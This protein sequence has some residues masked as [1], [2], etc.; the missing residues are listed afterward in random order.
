MRSLIIAG[1]A[2]LTLAACEQ[3]SCIPEYTGA[4]GYSC[5]KFGDR[6]SAKDREQ[7]AMK[8]SCNHTDTCIQYSNKMSLENAIKALDTCEKAFT[9]KAEEEQ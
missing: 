7:V 3:N 9:L 1:L 4:K 5:E 2:A 8:Y 6:I